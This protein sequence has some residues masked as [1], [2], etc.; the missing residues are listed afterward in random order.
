MGDSPHKE[1][2][3][4]QAAASLARKRASQKKRMEMLAAIMH[5]PGFGEHDS[6]NSLLE[7]TVWQRLEFAYEALCL[8]SRAR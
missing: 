8:L 3:A 2:L 1:Y 4:D 7:T 5:G 6:R